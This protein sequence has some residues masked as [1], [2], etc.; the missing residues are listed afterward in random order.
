MINEYLSDDRFTPRS[1][2]F[3]KA[4][5]KRDEIQQVLI[6]GWFQKFRIVDKAST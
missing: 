1:G 5:Q 6:N 4:G 3:E 2:C